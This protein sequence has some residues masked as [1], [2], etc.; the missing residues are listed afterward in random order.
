[1]GKGA[2]TW[3]Y[4]QNHSPLARLSNARHGEPS[5]RYKK[6]K[7]LHLRK[8]FA[9]DSTCGERLAVEAAGIYLAYSKNLITD[10]TL[11]SSFNSRKNPA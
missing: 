2:Q 10:E 8:L 5:K 9:D 4:S 11:K 3:K 6:V 1:M 7:K